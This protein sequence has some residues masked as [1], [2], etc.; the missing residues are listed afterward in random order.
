MDYRKLLGCMLAL[1]VFLGGLGLGSV[2]I[3]APIGGFQGIPKP[4]ATMT[5]A[6]C[7]LCHDNPA[8]VKPDYLPDRHHQLLGKPIPP[9]S[10]APFAGV[11]ANYQCLS[12]HNLTGPPGTPFFD[13]SEFR[14]CTK[15]H[16]APSGA[17][18]TAHH[19]AAISSAGDCTYCHK[20]PAFAQERPMQAACR[21]CHGRSM[22]DNGGPIQDY[23][24]CVSCHKNAA[25]TA[26]FPPPFHAAPGMAVGYT[27]IPKGQVSPGG[28]V[29]RAGKGTFAVFW[30]QYTRNGDEDF[31]EDNFS[32]IEPN[33]EDMN[34]EGGFRWRTPKLQ[35]N[36][37]QISSGGQLYNVPS[38]DGLPTTGPG[39]PLLQVSQ[40]VANATVSG[41]ID[42]R[43]TVSDNVR[44]HHVHYWVDQGTRVRMTGPDESASGTWS[45][46]W[47]TRFI[48]FKNK[49]VANPNGPHTL[50]IQAE[51][52]QGFLTTRQIPLTVNN[53]TGGG[54]PPPAGNLALGKTASASRQESGY[55]AAKAVDSSLT[56][57]WWARSTATQ[58]LRVDLGTSTSVSK[59][60]IDWHSDYA[61]DFSI[62]VS[63]DGSNWTTA[64]SV[65][66][67]G[68]GTQTH[69]FSA[70][71]A[72]YV[73][74]NCTRA[75]SFNGYSIEEL[76]VYQQ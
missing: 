8:V 4:Y 28:P 19:R 14:D 15:C 56:S 6:D 42:I 30:G 40:P 53:A 38:F 26:G 46:K 27:V 49:N 55:E 16:V 54:T 12:C 60:V 48:L 25:N 73:R 37:K 58:W 72:R 5:A 31:M 33:G 51:D 35:F 44:V 23:G 18:R 13:F 50:T 24:A 69:T 22:H 47:D 66:S 68:G 11:A 64:K 39:V 74:I 32:D 21:D 34:D 36:L 41:T 67:A 62:Q 61:R 57:R 63:T 3:G 65:T 20:V 59:V 9:G 2:A 17:T 29:Y 75:Y 70:R 7:N 1:G 45:A 10:E 76:E 71:N 52:N 43:A